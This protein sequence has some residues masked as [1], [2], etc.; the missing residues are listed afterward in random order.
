MTKYARPARSTSSP[1]ASRC[2]AASSTV[3]ATSSTRAREDRRASTGEARSVLGRDSFRAP[4]MVDDA[5]AGLPCLARRARSDHRSM[6]GHATESCSCLPPGGTLAP[7]GSGHSCHRA[8]AQGAALVSL[9]GT[10]PSRIRGP[11]HWTRPHTRPEPATERTIV[12]RA[13]PAPNCAARAAHRLA[14]RCSFSTARR[15]FTEHPAAPPC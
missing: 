10:P 13:T 1:S 12:R 2:P 8:S 4:R 3:C 14:R 6:M 15:A 11:S 9:I 5:N 7:S